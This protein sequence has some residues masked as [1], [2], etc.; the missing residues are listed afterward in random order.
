MGLLIIICEI[1]TIMYKC[2]LIPI[3]HSRCCLSWPG[4]MLHPPSLWMSWNPS[5]VKG[6]DL[7]L[8]GMYDVCSVCVIVCV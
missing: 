3:P 4:S 5:W 1:G 6:Q 2:S 8:Q 7:E